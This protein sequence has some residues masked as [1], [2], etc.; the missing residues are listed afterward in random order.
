[1]LPPKS[2]SGA[3]QPT[4]PVMPVFR[5]GPKPTFDAAAGLSPEQFTDRPNIWSQ[6]SSFRSYLRRKRLV[7]VPLPKK[8]RMDHDALV[9]K[10]DSR[11]SSSKRFVDSH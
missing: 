11:H 1:L 9:C 5:S 7:I 8:D 3:E 10:C 6:M 2:A 4:S